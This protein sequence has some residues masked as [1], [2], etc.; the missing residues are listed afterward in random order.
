MRVQPKESTREHLEGSFGCA[1]ALFS[2]LE[3]ELGLPELT[4][5]TAIS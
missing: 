1:S 2:T 5:E 3:G 4:V